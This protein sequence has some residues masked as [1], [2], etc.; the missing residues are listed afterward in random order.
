[1]SLAM[2]VAVYLQELIAIILRHLFQNLDFISHG[3]FIKRIS[4]ILI[5]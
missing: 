5:A 2:V 4:N 3:Y 1:M